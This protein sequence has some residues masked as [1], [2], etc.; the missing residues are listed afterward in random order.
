M[1]GINAVW[2]T[3]PGNRLGYLIGLS[4]TA[5]L[6]C[7]DHPRIIFELNAGQFLITSSPRAFLN[8]SS[9][10]IYSETTSGVAYSEVLIN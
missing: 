8:L 4:I 5:R 9:L 3:V 6:F 7:L 10:L 2:D 1:I